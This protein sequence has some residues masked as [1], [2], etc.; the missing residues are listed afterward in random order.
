MTHLLA[1]S[2][3]VVSAVDRRDAN[4]LIGL[5]DPK[6]QIRGKEKIDIENLPQEMMVARKQLQ[7]LQIAHDSTESDNFMQWCLLFLN[8][9]KMLDQQGSWTVGNGSQT[10]LF[11][12]FIDC[13]KAFEKVCGMDFFD[14]K[15]ISPI[16]E[17]MTELLV[18]YAEDA[19]EENFA[20]PYTKSNAFVTDSNSDSQKVE[21]A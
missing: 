18:T 15:W 14:G 2:N 12:A 16:V 5:L 10:D 8:H 7:Q 6:M 20:T 13:F 17:H 9:S 19:D 1:W 4:K 3:N 21:K 11:N